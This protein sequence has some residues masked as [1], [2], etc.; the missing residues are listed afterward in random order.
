MDL[1]Q[2]VSR[3]YPLKYL[4]YTSEHFFPVDV[5][6]QPPTKYENKQH[7]WRKHV[8]SLV[9]NKKTHMYIQYSQQTVEFP[10]VDADM[11]Q[12]EVPD[13]LCFQTV[14]L[15]RQTN[16]YHHSKDILLTKMELIGRF[17]IIVIKQL[18]DPN[19]NVLFFLTQ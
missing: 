12:Q 16:D 9:H 18:N 19:K 7:F 13:G 8:G 14:G 1:W 11:N 10:A 2:L 17:D 3:N 4:K 5:Y 6:D 15:E